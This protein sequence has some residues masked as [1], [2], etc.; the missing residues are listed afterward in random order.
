MQSL[1]REAVVFTGESWET[2]HLIPFP[3]SR[4]DPALQK[5]VSLGTQPSTIGSS[6]LD[7]ELLLSKIIFLPEVKW[8]QGFLGNQRPLFR[9][10]IFTEDPL[11]AG[12]GTKEVTLCHYCLHR[13]A[14]VEGK[15][16]LKHT[17][18]RNLKLEGARP[19]ESTVV[20]EQITRDSDLSRGGQTALGRCRA[21][22]EAGRVL[23]KRWK[24]M[25]TE[26]SML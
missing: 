22:R 2:R 13:S 16:K 11:W 15:E 7:T 25:W 24:S 23:V 4:W 17:H 1:W 18:I 14:P 9:Q 26:E 21:M 10:Q 12:L 5:H 20:C 6:S 8:V 19:D 3:E